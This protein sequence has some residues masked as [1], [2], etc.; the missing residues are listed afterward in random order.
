MC[1]KYVTSPL[2]YFGIPSLVT[3]K[4]SALLK[5][6][7]G[8]STPTLLYGLSAY[9]GYQRYKW[10]T[11][12][13]ANKSATLVKSIKITNNSTVVIESFNYF[14][15]KVLISNLDNWIIILK[16]CHKLLW[17]FNENNPLLHNQRS[18]LKEKIL[19]CTWWKLS[20]ES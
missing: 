6:L 15:T 19:S 1:S 13:D 20:F 17:Q 18:S 8:A 3:F 7:F 16:C 14:G 5:L 4:Y 9:F 11:S 2:I 12:G 10:L